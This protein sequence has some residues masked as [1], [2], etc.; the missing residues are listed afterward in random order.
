[1]AR[2][3]PASSEEY[4]KEGGNKCPFCGSTDIE[5]DQVTIDAGKAY[6]PVGCNDCEGEWTDVYKLEG[7]THELDS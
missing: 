3:V 7:F 6:Q 5:G 4:V 1:M 2:K